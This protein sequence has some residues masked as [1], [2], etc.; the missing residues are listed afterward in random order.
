[1]IGCGREAGNLDGALHVLT[2]HVQITSSFV[3]AALIASAPRYRP[4]LGKFS[5]DMIE[6]SLSHKDPDKVR[7][8]YARGDFAAERV[9]MAKWWADYLDML[10][11]ET[12]SNVLALTGRRI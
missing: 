1:M 4:N 12:G 8:A 6:L 7:S 3:D 5:S 2:G 9:N 10:R 11:G